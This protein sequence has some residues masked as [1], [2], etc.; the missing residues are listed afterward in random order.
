MEKC[1]LK[2]NLNTVADLVSEL[3]MNYLDTL[4]CGI[5]LVRRSEGVVSHTTAASLGR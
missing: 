4:D 2:V 1:E 5:P 3:R